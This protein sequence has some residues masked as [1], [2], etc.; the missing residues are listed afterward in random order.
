[1]D[2][3][4]RQSKR[5]LA[6]TAELPRTL[7]QWLEWQRGLHPF[8]VDLGLSRVSEVAGRMG[9]TRPGRRVLTVAGTN[10]K[11]SCVALA[12][13][14]LLAG[15]YRV[16]AYTSPHLLR[17]NERVR[18]EGREVPDAVLVRAFRAV[19]NARGETGL[20]EFEFSTLAVL[21]VFEEAR[22]DVAVLEVGLGGRLDAVNIVD[23]DVAIIAS[24]AIDHEAWLGS[25]RESVGREKAGIMRSGI[26]VICGDASPPGSVLSRARE[27]DCDL[28]VRDQDFRVRRSGNTWDLSGPAGDL[29]GLPLP[30]LEG[31]VQLYNAA[32]VLTALGALSNECQV[33]F[34]AACEGLTSVRLAGRR[35]RFGPDGRVM[36]DIAHNP[37]AAAMLADDLRAAPVRGVNLAVFGVL[38]DKDLRGIVDG[39]EG[40]FQAWFVASPGSPRGRAGETVRDVLLECSPGTPVTV[41]EDLV[42]ALGEARKQACADDRIVVFGSAF[43]TGEV[44]HS[45]SN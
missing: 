9:L 21:Q 40:V 5:S 1:M 10:G 16:G 6:G 4:T 15:G 39:V 12:E 2:L 29:S 31:H 22:L 43:G 8:E 19:E 18:I 44:L 27:L 30:A 41:C 17:Y 14:I 20:S 13:S 25:D 24:I 33:S 42:S 38:R 36:L 23:P 34:E 37:A 7:E 26:P 35:Q 45:L 11:G 3:V 32:T 28:L